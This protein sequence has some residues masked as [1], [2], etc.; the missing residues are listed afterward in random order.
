VHLI[1]LDLMIAII[2]GEQYKLWTF[3]FADLCFMQRIVFDLQELSSSKR[4]S[5][6]DAVVWLT[7][8]WLF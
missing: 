8:L 2:F 7:G 3:L 4:N 1:L 6:V 5:D